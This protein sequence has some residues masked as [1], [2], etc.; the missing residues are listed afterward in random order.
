MYISICI[1][2]STHINMFIMFIIIIIICINYM[3]R[4]AAARGLA[5][6]TGRGLLS[7]SRLTKSNYK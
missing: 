3:S 6:M 7:V 4:E 1:H 5:P 2:T